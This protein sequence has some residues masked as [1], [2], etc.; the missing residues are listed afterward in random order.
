MGTLLVIQ[1][2]A[3]VVTGAETERSVDLSTRI[4]RPIAVQYWKDD[5]ARLYV[6]NQRS[7]SVSTVDLQTNR[8]ETSRISSRAFR[9]QGLRYIDSAELHSVNSDVGASFRSSPSNHRRTVIA[10]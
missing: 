4:R 8:L 3:V 2:A 6:A 10:P 7:G 1:L 5:H 9:T